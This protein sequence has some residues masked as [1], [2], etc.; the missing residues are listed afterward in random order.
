[1]TTTTEIATRLHKVLFGGRP[2]FRVTA[3]DHEG[4]GY[5]A[6]EGTGEVHGPGAC[7]L[8]L[9]DEVAEWLEE[10]NDPA[11]YDDFCTSLRTAEDEQVA[12]ALLREL[13]LRAHAEGTCEPVIPDVYDV[14]GDPI[15]VGNYV[16]TVGLAVEDSDFG[17]VLEV[18][19][20]GCLDV[21][22][23]GAE[24]RT[25]RTP[26]D[27]LRIISFEAYCALREGR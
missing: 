6:T 17:E 18:H 25:E 4:V 22:W 1:M 20:D 15:G 11:D 2:D 8:Y 24:A 14:D 23:A 21:Y 9:A 3:W 13:G 16:Q 27:G 5:L 10:A 19:P 7:F 26:A 12:R